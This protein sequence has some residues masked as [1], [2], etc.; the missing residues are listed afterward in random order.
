MYQGEKFNSLSHFAGGLL[1]SAGA[2]VLIT[3]AGMT[4]DM[5]KILGACIY[6]VGMVLVYVSS[7]LYHSTFGPMKP[8]LRK[9]DHISIY[10]MIAGTYTP[11]C[12]VTLRNA[13]GYWLLAT[14]WICAALG[15]VLEFTLAHRTRVPSLAL[16][17]LMSLLCLF[18]LQPLAAGIPGYGFVWL[19]LG[20][21]LYLSG[22]FF[23]I[24]DDRVPH[25]HGIWHLFVIGGSA[26]QY[27][28][29]LYCILK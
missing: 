13:G 24:F 25:F 27:L 11:F 7:T 8:V 10:L 2:A 19:L 29:V 20:G 9:F 14:V 23:Y 12:L 3:F 6:G 15:A 4:G 26:C 1:A 21:L 28:C 18:A 17:F 5:S 16:Y 22:F